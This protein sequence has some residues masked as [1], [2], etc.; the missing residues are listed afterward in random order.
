MSRPQ[1]WRTAVAA[2]SLLV[3]GAAVGVAADRVLH[4]GRRT[5]V[6]IHQMSTQGRL[7]LLDRE[8]SLRPEQR[9]RIEGILTQRQADVDRAWV[10]ARA[11][12]RAAVDS[13]V[14]EIEATLDPAHRERYRVLV[15]QVHGEDGTIVPKRVRLPGH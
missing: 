7:E 4:R 1:R 14:T 5:A 8:L 10:N 11:A 12:L 9:E 13:V 6:S 2:A 3:L 15:R